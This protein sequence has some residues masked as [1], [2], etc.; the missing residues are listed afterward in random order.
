M[1][2]LDQRILIGDDIE[3]VYV[4]SSRGAARLGV[5]APPHIRVDRKE[6]ALGLAKVQRRD[7]PKK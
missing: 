1:L 2:R 6:V 5:K 3:V 7:M 4:N